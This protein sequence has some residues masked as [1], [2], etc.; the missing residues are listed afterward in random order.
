MTNRYCS[1]FL[2]RFSMRSTWRCGN[3]GLRA[4][5]SYAKQ[6]SAICAIIKESNAPSSLA[7]TTKV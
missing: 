3:K 7:S 2:S 6:S 4:P 5:N 1:I